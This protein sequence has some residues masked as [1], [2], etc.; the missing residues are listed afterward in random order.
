[1]SYDEIGR[2]G[3]CI[4]FENKITHKFNVQETVET[5]VSVNNSR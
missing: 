3:N 1:M 5:I 4:L 2:L